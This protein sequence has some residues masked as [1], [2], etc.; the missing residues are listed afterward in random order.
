MTIGC[1][2]LDQLDDD[3][4]LQPLTY[5]FQA[6][7]AIAY[8]ASL[9]VSAF[10]GEALPSNV[11]FDPSSKD[12][13]DG[14]GIIHIDVSP[15]NPL[16][17]NS[18]TGDIFI[19]GLWNGNSG[20]ISIVFADIDILSSDFEFYGLHT[21]PVFLNPNGDITTLFAEQDIVIGQGSD[22]LLN[23][24]LSNPKFQLEQNRLNNPRPN[25]FFTAIAQKVWYMEIDRNN[26]STVFD[27]A[28]TLTGGG[29]VLEARSTSGGILY[30]ALIDTEFNYQHCSQNPTDGTAF[31]QNIKVGSSTDLGNITFGFRDE[32]DGKANVI[33]ATGKYVGSNGRNINLNWN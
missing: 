3:P 18:H 1:N 9:T 16:P 31:I 29:Q 22:T 26:L 10:K 11:T 27:D 19:A 8:C 5:G 13:Y 17:F 32:C 24:S 4:E 33:V 15:S 25:D 12:G 21:V 23:L 2:K 7:A 20:V 28:V 30:H 14:A 6:S